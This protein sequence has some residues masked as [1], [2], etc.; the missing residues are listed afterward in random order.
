MNKFFNISS[1]C[2]LHE[3]HT[4]C[5]VCVEKATWLSHVGT[6]ATD[7]GGKVNDDIWL[8]FVV[9]ANDISLV[10]KIVVA[11]PRYEDLSVWY[12]TVMQHLANCSAKKSGSTSDDNSLFRKIDTVGHGDDS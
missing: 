2:L 11:T 5:H 8:E 3:V 9:H 4:H 1:A 6:D 10:D 12:A 7:L